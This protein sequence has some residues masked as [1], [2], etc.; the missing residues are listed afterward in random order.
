MVPA[1]VQT[2]CVNGCKE[3]AQKLKGRRLKEAWEAP[4]E[5][6]AFDV[7]PDPALAE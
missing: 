5:L 3:T 1:D 7:V 4:S 2:G 6:S